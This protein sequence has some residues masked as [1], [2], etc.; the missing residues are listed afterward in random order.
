MAIE[1]EQEVDPTVPYPIHCALCLN[2]KARDN[3]VPAVTI[4]RGYAT[5]ASHA[6]IFRSHDFDFPAYIQSAKKRGIV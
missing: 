5:C 1:D 3:L 4:I 2:L 6:A